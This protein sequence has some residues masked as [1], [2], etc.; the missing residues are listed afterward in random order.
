MKGS[1]L[2]MRDEGTKGRRTFSSQQTKQSK[3]NQRGK[4]G[5]STGGF[6]GGAQ[7]ERKGE[8]N[9]NKKE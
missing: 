9:N 5:D 7:K 2:N 4:G 8:T 6:L 1:R 3:G